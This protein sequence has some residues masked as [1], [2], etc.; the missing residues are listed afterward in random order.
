M[1]GDIYCPKCILTILIFCFFHNLASATAPSLISTIQTPT[2]GDPY[3]IAAAD[4]NQD[5]KID[6]VVA[7]YYDL[8]VY[9][10][11]G[12]GTFGSPLSLG[13]PADVVTVG[14]FNNDGKV[15]IAFFSSEAQEAGIFLGNGDGTFRFSQFFSL[16]YYASSLTVA[17]LND[18]GKLDIIATNYTEQTVILVFGDGQGGFTSP[19][20][21]AV[22]YYPSGITVADFNHDGVV[23]FAVANLG[24][25]F[26]DSGPGSVMVFLGTGHGVFQ[27]GMTISSSNFPWSIASGDFNGDGKADLA[28]IED[29]TSF[30]S[31]YVRIYLGNGDGTFTLDGSYFEPGFYEQV[32][33]ADLNGDGRT[34][35]VVL[36]NFYFGSVV[37]F[38]KGDGSFAAP[39]EYASGFNTNNLIVADVNGDGR[40]DFILGNFGGPPSIG[41]QL[42][43]SNGTYKAAPI[44]P[45]PATFGFATGDFNHDGNLDLVTTGTSGIGISLGNGDGTLQPPVFYSSGDLQGV[46][47]GDFNN[48]GNVDVAA[49]PTANNSVAIYLGN[50][51]GTLR[52]LYNCDCGGYASAIAVAD[53]NGDGNLDLGV[54]NILNNTVTINFGDGHGHF[55]IGEVIPV[56]L[57]PVLAAAGEIIHKGGN[58][59]HKGGNDLLV[60]NCGTN[61]QGGNCPSNPNGSVSVLL[62]QGNGTFV[63]A[64]NLGLAQPPA[65]VAVGDFNGDGKADLAV[66]EAFSNESTLYI[67]LGNGDGTFQQEPGGIE[68]SGAATV[69]ATDLNGDGK[70]D[71]ITLGGVIT[72][73]L[74]N[75][76]GTFQPGTAFPGAGYDFFLGTIGDFNNDGAPDLATDGVSIY[77]NAAGT[78]I[79]FVASPNPSLPDTPIQLTARVSPSYNGVGIGVPRGTVTFEDI[80]TFPVT[81]LASAQLESGVAVATVTNLSPGGHALQPVYS[82]D[83]NFNRH[84]GSPLVEKITSGENAGPGSGGATAVQALSAQGGFGESTETGAVEPQTYAT[85]LARSDIGSHPLIGSLTKPS[86]VPSIEAL[87]LP[88]EPIVAA[89]SNFSGFEG[90]SSL[91]SRSVLGNPDVE[92][93]DQGLAVSSTQVLE[94]VNDVVALYST[95]GSIVSG[96][97]SLN[98]FFGLPPADPN[99]SAGYGPFLSDPR[100]LYDS[101]TQRWFVTAIEVSTDPSNGNLLPQATLLIA[102]STESDATKPFNVFAIDATDAGFGTCPC[103]GDHPNIATNHDGLF[104]STNQYSFEDQSF[105]TA[106]VLA[107]DKYRL[108]QGIAPPAIGFQDLS[109][110]STNAYALMPS[111]AAP[112]DASASGT[113]YFLSSADEISVTNQGGA[114]NTVTVW[115]LGNTSSLSSA[116]P[117]LTLQAVTLSGETYMQPIAATQKNGPTPLRD[118]LIQTN[119]PEPFEKLDQDDD[120]FQA[121]SLAQGNLFGVLSTSLFAF[122]GGQG[123]GVAWFSITPTMNSG[124]LTAK[125]SNQGYI[126]STEGDVLYPAV[127]VNARGQG[128]ITFSMSGPTLFPGVGYVSIKNG[129]VAD[130]ISTAASGADPEDGFTG[131]LYY[132]GNGIARWGDYSGAT[133]DPAGNIW[134]ASEYIP[135]GTNRTILADWGTFIATLTAQ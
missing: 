55:K 95:S 93:P 119:G 38:G 56:G 7:E 110:Y 26:G 97:I 23:D 18:D 106:V 111:Q 17:D 71:L 13:T 70:I 51:D 87:I 14:D 96:P 109:V 52:F 81:T 20:R 83:S 4:F 43:N 41:V 28:V 11:N 29:T 58:D 82:G 21:Y 128:A 80:S 108:A 113:E 94:A 134:F 39:K 66:L 126:S 62:N 77:L 84:I 34:D 40:L 73:F 16:G 92:P 135:G 36:D 5:G 31:S 6:V 46:A 42:G 63:Q 98:H 35:L 48:D 27:Q 32:S 91:D 61:P 131:Y 103:L 10:G 105:Q 3:S 50:G 59:L 114:Q 2:V 124:T 101:D 120:R 104:I 117:V 60:L 72:V 25:L 89:G 19:V 76:D 85:P 107:L 65:S 88:G 86:A 130:S 15:D 64:P 47:T 133:V 30:T 78:R 53:F 49:G 129:A 44:Y 57:Y 8:R 9:T 123:S 67:F 74:G 118:Y 54:T 69:L 121:V 125:I 37:F 33:A 24:G 68:I 132:G 1:D 102:A 22:G 116:S 115:A 122:G 100:V 12:D 127:A 112:G 75:G 99:G 45:N 79:S 90:L